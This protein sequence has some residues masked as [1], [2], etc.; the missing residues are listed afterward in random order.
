VGGGEG[1][2]GGKGKDMIVPRYGGG[3]YLLWIK[4]RNSQRQKY[5]RRAQSGRYPEPCRV[6]KRGRET[7]SNRM[8]QPRGQRYKKGQETEMSG[9]YREEPLGGKDSPATG[10]ERSAWLPG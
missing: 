8:L 2:K 10:L 5:T 4:E 9:L 7:R 6:R 3:Q 1:G